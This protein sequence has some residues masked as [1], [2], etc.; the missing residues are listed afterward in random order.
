MGM[1]SLLL[2]SSLKNISEEGIAIVLGYWLNDPK[3]Y[4]VVEFDKQG[5]VISIEEKPSNQIFNYA[6]V[7]LYFYTNEVVEIVKNIMS[8]FNGRNAYKLEY[9]KKWHWTC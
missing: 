7:G 3:R 2:A 6:V 9:M 8:F 1:G 4:I 5:K